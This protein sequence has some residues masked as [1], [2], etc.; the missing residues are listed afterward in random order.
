MCPRG[1]DQIAQ[2]DATVATT[3]FGTALGDSAHG[4]VDESHF[5]SH[6]F[7]VQCNEANVAGHRNRVAG[8]S[9]MKVTK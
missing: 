5:G 6:N 3:Q 8:P 7:Q 2:K 9:L 1:S 4:N